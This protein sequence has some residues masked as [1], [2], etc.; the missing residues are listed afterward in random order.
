[1]LDFHRALVQRKYRLLF[2]PK[3]KNKPGPKGPTADLIRSAVEMKHRNPTWGCPH[4]ADQINLAFG[5]SINKD[6]VRRILARHYRSVPTEGG[7]SWL[8]FIGHVKDSLWS[9]DPF[10][11]ESISLR[12][13]WV[14]VVMDQYT[15]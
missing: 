12:T 9:I 4:I 5:T 2:S 8:T 13:Y 7:P 15:R 10:R 11:C 6:I 14:L 3:Q 1:L